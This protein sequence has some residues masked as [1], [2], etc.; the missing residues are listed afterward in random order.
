YSRSSYA[1]Y[2]AASQMMP[3]YSHYG[4]GGFLAQP[5]DVQDRWSSLWVRTGRGIVHPFVHRHPATGRPSLCLFMGSHFVS[6]DGGRR[7]TDTASVFAEVGAA[8]HA[9]QH[10]VY[11]HRWETGDLLIH[12]NLATAHL[13]SAGTQAPASQVGLRV[14]DRAAVAGARPLRAWAPERLP[15]HSGGGQETARPSLTSKSAAASCGACGT[16][17]FATT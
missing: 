16:H 4:A 10:L 1:G 7:A 11:R 8:I 12:D 13:A 5:P 3:S 17:R 15:E 6:F 9:A 14:L 2:P